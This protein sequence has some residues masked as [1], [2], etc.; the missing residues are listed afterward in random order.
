MLD[1][2]LATMTRFVSLIK[3]CFL[4]KLHVAGNEAAFCRVSH[5]GAQI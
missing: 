2:L 3:E 4:E 1:D 5:A